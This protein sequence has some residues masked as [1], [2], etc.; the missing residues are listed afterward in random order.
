[1]RWLVLLFGLELPVLLAFLDAWNRSAHQFPGGKA[2]RDAWVRWLAI[3]M[4]TAPLL[5]GYGI[6]TGYYHAVIKRN[7]PT[8]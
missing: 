6:V 3:A 2:D 5:I 7:A 8:T 4:L 1:M